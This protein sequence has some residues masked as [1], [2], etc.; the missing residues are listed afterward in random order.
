[1]IKV[2]LL[3]LKDQN[4]AL[5]EE[6]LEAIKKVVQSQ[7]FILGKAVQ[8]FEEKV[9][10]YCGS[11]TA[12]GVSSGTDALLVSLLG[13]DIGPGD[14]VVTTPYS[15][16]AT[17][18]SIARTGAKPVFV[19]IDPLTFNINPSLI[20]SRINSN[21]KAIMPVHLYGQCA[22]MD[23]ILDLA[24]DKGL[25]V[26]EDA[27]QSFGA[28]YKNKQSGSLGTTG[29]FS[30]FPSKNLGGMGDGGLIL[31]QDETL[32]QKIKSLRVHGANPKY[33]HPLLGG[34]FRLDA[35]QAA[36]L[37]VKLPY[38]NKWISSRR[39]NAQNYQA[40][41]SENN[42]D[43][44][45]V[46]LPSEVIEGHTYNQF[47][48]RV[49]KRDELREYLKAQGIITEVYYPHPLHLQ[50]CFSSLGYEAGDFPET[51][52]ACKENLALPIYPEMSEDQQQIVVNTIK[53]FYV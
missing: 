28:S 29:C 27:A 25:A 10:E 31:V 35:L 49:P 15:F 51:E 47:M 5:E 6:I 2:P 42:L 40:L 8:E 39:Q 37:N 52:K 30:F 7:Q 44:Y 9:A 12:I 38:V 21:T 43:Q 16:F 3:D 53:E 14:E 32:A 22:D 1:M 34:N 13:L 19:D 24:K 45:D 26:I 20:Q 36:I 4:T 18:G 33:Y 46:I 11:G 17:A 50:E 23:P 41:F 48:I